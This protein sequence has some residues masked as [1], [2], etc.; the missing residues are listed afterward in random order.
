MKITMVGVMLLLF[1]HTVPAGAFDLATR[2]S[3]HDGTVVLSS[4]GYAKL[5]LIKLKT[6]SKGL[7]HLKGTL[8]IDGKA[9]MVLWAK[10]DGRYYFSKLPRL[11]NIR[12]QKGV[13]FK[14]P[15]NTADKTITEVILEVELLQGGTLE[16]G[17]IALLN[18]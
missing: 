5:N 18:G 16:V 12:D 3:Q 9:N 4:T 10:V 15:F 13:H 1:V 6:G 17:D 11:Q 8:S 14:I 7:I 2:I